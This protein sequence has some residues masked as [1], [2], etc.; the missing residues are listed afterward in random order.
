LVH[1]L[2][3]RIIVKRRV[4]SK[5]TMKSIDLEVIYVCIIFNIVL[6]RVRPFLEEELS[7]P[8]KLRTQCVQFYSVSLQTTQYLCR[9]TKL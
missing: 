5:I 8:K 6:I 3:N 1:I 7:G 9:I 2:S 4:N